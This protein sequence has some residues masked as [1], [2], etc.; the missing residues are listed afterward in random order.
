[1]VDLLIDKIAFI[2]HS[3]QAADESEEQLGESGAF[4]MTAGYIEDKTASTLLVH[5][6]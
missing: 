3:N 6:H 1:M 4:D 5:S 2:A